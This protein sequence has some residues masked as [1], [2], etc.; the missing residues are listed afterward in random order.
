MRRVL[1]GF[2]AWRGDD[3]AGKDVGVRNR[4]WGGGGAVGCEDDA[5]GTR[6]HLRDMVQQQPRSSDPHPPEMSP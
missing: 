5:H 1:E 3:V 4:V 2:A 6:A